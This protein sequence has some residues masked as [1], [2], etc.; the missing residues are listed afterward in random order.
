MRT[1]MSHCISSQAIDGFEG[2]WAPDPVTQETEKR[3][4]LKASKEKLS[5]AHTWVL[6]QKLHSDACLSETEPHEDMLS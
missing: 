3:F 4:S 2:Q 1:N 6:I 5:S